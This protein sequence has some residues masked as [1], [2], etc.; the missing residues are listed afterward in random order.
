LRPYIQLVQKAL[1]FLGDTQSTTSPARRTNPR[2]EHKLVRCESCETW[3]P[4]DR[5]LKL[6]GGLAQYCSREC[7]EKSASSKEHRAAG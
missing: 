5:A 7:L 6:S 2:A 3:I 4:E 1:K